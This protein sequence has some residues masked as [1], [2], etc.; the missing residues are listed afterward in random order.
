MTFRPLAMHCD[1]EGDFSDSRDYISTSNTLHI[2]VWQ[3]DR[4][5]VEAAMSSF[6][7]G[8]QPATSLEKVGRGF[9]LRRI[10]CHI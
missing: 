9:T 10:R 2:S 3:L 5:G 7:L 8:R 6:A 1:T 4:D